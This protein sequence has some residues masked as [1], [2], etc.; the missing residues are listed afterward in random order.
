M[1]YLFYSLPLD[2]NFR[3]ERDKVKR[4]YLIIIHILISFSVLAQNV[5]TGTCVTKDGGQYE[6]E[7]IGS[8]PHGKGHC[9][10]KN[11]DTYDGEYKKGAREG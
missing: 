10:Y 3:T 4:I 1:S 9:V 7:M 5:K 8:K 11:G 2:W 6:G